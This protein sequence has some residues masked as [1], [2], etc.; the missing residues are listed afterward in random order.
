MLRRSF[1]ALMVDGMDLRRRRVIGL[2]RLGMS[3]GCRLRCWRWLRLGARVISRGLGDNAVASSLT[4]VPFRLIQA[5]AIAGVGLGIGHQGVA[6][7]GEYCGDG[8]ETH[9]A[10]G[11]RPVI[12]KYEIVEG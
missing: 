2:S 8:C 4:I 6:S 10:K 9:G 1:V 7:Q 3:Y 12:D 5:I 11:L